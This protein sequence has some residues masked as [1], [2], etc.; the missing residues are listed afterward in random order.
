MAMIS[1]PYHPGTRVEEVDPTSQSKRVGTVMGILFDPSML[2]QYLI[3]FDNGTTCSVPA[4][5]M[6]NLIPKPVIS[7]SDTT[8]LLP[9]FLKV[10]SKITYKHDGQFHKGFLSKMPEG[11]YRFS[12]KSHI[13]KKNEDWGINIPNLPTTWQ[14]LCTNGILLPGHQP[15]LFLRLPPS[16]NFVSAKTLK[17][18]CPRSLLVALA[19]SHPNQAIW[20]NS[21]RKE[22]FDIQSQ[23]TYVK[24][25]L[26]EYQ[27]LRA[28]GAPRTIPLVCVLT[29]KKDK[30][31]NPLCAKSQIVALG[32]H[33]DR[34]WTKSDKYAPVL[35]SYLMHLFTSRSKNVALSSKVIARMPFVKASY[36]T[37]KLP[38][39][40][41]QSGTRMLKR[42][43]IGS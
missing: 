6:P 15:L 40:N 23:D 34:I 26:A 10:G 22:K 20:L 17:R 8:H 33:E 11:V 43:N 2:P 25:G 3:M 13:N 14:D 9:P 39:S 29:I 31:F 42:T 35:R 30:M 4:S 41:H 38:S 5:K 12:Y 21:F 27:A 18:E 24:I 37:T 19:P 16:T 28:K 32:N 1:E 36:L 7:V